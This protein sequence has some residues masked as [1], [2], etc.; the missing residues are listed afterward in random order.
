VSE[1]IDAGGFNVNRLSRAALSLDLFLILIVCGSATLICI[2]PLQRTRRT[3]TPDLAPQSGE[4]DDA[5]RNG[6]DIV[7]GEMSLRPI[8]VARPAVPSCPDSDAGS[9]SLTESQLVDHHEPFFNGIDPK[10]TC[11]SARRQW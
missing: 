10:R 11:T 6:G 8:V 4:H 5:R 3:V 7:D 2:K 9:P 1:F